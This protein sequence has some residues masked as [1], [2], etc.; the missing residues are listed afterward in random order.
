MTVLTIMINDHHHHNYD[1]ILSY[2]FLTSRA[3]DCGPLDY[4]QAEGELFLSWWWW[5]WLWWWWWW[6]WWFHLKIYSW[7][8]LIVGQLIMI[9]ENYH[10]HYD[11]AHH[12]DQYHCHHQHN[13]HA[14]LH[15]HRHH[16]HNAYDHHD[17]HCHCHPL[18]GRFNSAEAK[19]R[20]RGKCCP[21]AWRVRMSSSSSS[22][23]SSS[24]QFDLH[25]FVIKVIIVPGVHGV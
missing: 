16:Q 22:T 9:Y 12:H 20:R 10:K 3:I 14:H 1:N 11:Q 13:G 18:S 6:W 2:E 24:F 25:E 8:G 15:D 5:W 19:E 7:Q 23:S 17:H 4:N 21:A